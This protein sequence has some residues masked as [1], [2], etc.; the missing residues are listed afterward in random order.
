MNTMHMETLFLIGQIV[1]GIYFIVSGVKHF[2]QFPGTVGYAT[3]KKLPAP[4]LSV[5]VTGAM[6]VIGGI[7]VLFQWQIAI[8]YALLV[9]FL[10]GAAVFVHTFWKE[11]DPAARMGDRINFEKNLALAAAL[12]MLLASAS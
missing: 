3:F 9:M 6:L 4:K 5:A 10:V 12:L 11:K 7:G 8:T 1:L 2:T